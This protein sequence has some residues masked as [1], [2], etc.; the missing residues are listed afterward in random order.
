MFRQ[1][2]KD[3]PD[4]YRIEQSVAHGKDHSDKLIV[5]YI[6]IYIYVC[7]NVKV[8]RLHNMYLLEKQNRELTQDSVHVDTLR[9]FFSIPVTYN[10]SF[11]HYK[12]I[13]V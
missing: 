9:I 1:H 3:C 7:I 11:D 2:V 12:I 13:I 10:L 4:R 8:K 5:I 6:Y